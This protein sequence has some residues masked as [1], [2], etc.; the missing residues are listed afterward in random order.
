[1]A[2]S[3]DGSAAAVAASGPCGTPVAAAAAVVVV[4]LP[5][6]AGPA[7]IGLTRAA[8]RQ[9]GAVDTD[10]TAAAAVVAASAV[11]GAEF[12]VYAGTAAVEEAGLARD[13]ATPAGAY[14][15]TWALLAAPAAVL[16]VTLGVDTFS[17]AEGGASR[18]DEGAETVLASLAVGADDAAFATM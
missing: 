6:D 7:A 10:P 13:L 5:V 17:S 3:A 4:G 8:K 2:C 18:A 9:A 11:N 1:M 14:L 12:Y 15:A 16:V